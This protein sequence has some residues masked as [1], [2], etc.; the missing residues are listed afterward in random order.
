MSARLLPCTHP[1]IVLRLDTLLFQVFFMVEELLLCD[2]QIFLLLYKRQG[3]IYLIA[4]GYK[5]AL[6]WASASS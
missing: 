2:S 1:K 3:C 4:L 5:H 6:T